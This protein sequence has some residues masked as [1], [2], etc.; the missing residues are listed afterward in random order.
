[1]RGLL[2]PSVIAARVR[3]VFRINV[4]EE[5]KACTVPILYLQASKDILV[6]P[7]NLRAIKR[8][9]Q[10]IKV[11]KIPSSHMILQRHPTEAVA[12]IGAFI[13]ELQP[14]SLER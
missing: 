10:G 1:M 2:R 4:Q 8:I 5:L 6:P 14:I 3:M 13:A 12:A 11:S 7:W 9:N